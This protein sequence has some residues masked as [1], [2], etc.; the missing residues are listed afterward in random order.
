MR[1]GSVGDV[2]DLAV[3]ESYKMKQRVLM[4]ASEAAEM[5][6]QSIV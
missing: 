1:A 3:V 2:R 4:S 5:L 6:I